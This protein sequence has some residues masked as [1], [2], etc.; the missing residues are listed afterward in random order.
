MNFEYTYIVLFG[1]KVFEPV[2]LLTN[3]LIIAFALHAYFKTKTINNNFSRYWS[4]FFLLM[5]TSC[6]SGTLSHAIH[7]QLGHLFLKVSWFLM[8]ALS[9]IS[10]YFFY[11]AAFSYY[12]LN[13]TDI[14]KVYNYLVVVWIILL[15]VATLFMNSFLLIKIHAGIVLVYSL[16]VHG[17]TYKNKQIGSGYIVAGILISFLSII[18]HSFKLS[19]GEW[20][21]Y[22]D[23]AHVI[24]LISLMYLHRGIQEKEIVATKL[25]RAN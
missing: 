14:S 4:M 7:D 25:A 5:A 24:M 11:R 17:I 23:I 13:K 18:V 9:L 1:Y 15:L 10:I 8:N 6:A 2:T 19:V 21:N 12:N 3:G 16:I 22:K 20:F